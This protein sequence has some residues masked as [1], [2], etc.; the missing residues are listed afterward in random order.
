MKDLPAEDIIAAYAAG[1]T[2]RG[3]GARYG[4]GSA[5]I[6]RLLIRNDVKIRV[7]RPP[8]L[9]PDQIREARQKY[10]DGLS[11][12]EIAD[13]YGVSNQAVLR[14]LDDQERHPK[15]TARRPD[16]PADEIVGW[17]QTGQTLTALASTYGTT[18]ETVRRILDRAGVP[19][20]RAHRL[21]TLPAAEV[22]AA[23]QQGATTR[24]LGKT[25]GVGGDTI[26]QLLIKHDVRMRPTGSPAALTEEQR[27]EAKELFRQGMRKS[28]IARHF[29]VSQSVVGNL[30]RN[31]PS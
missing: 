13:Q 31:Q 14:A 9:S 1:G 23:Y 6:R 20:R 19:A 29:N 25:Y 21:D 4:V 28:D 10:S 22:I 7:T 24:A 11:S 2:L 17:Y 27:A 5:T 30:L 18:E 3:I 15:G 12:R 8:K 26:R 16:L